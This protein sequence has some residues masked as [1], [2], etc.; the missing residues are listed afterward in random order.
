MYYRNKVIPVDD[1]GLKLQQPLAQKYTNQKE[2]NGKIQE[3][4]ETRGSTCEG[5]VCKRI[6]M[7]FSF[8]CER[9]HAVKRHR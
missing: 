8:V 9:H 4:E 6:L 3:S 7:S 5:I 2:P 1:H